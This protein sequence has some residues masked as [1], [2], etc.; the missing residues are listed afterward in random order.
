MLLDSNGWEAES[1]DGGQYLQIEF[2]TR[3]TLIAIGTM[4]RAVSISQVISLLLMND[5]MV[6]KQHFL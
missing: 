2:E 5:N 4:G 3:M 6:F 1:T